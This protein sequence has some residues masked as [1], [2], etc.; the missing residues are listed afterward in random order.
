MFDADG[1][2]A[3]PHASAVRR[4]AD[5]CPATTSTSAAAARDRSFRD[6]GITFSP[7]GE[8]WVFPLD[9]IPRLIAEDEWELIEAGV[10]Q[11]VRALEA[12]LA[13]VY[14]A[15][16]CSATASCPTRWCPRAATSAGRRTASARQRASAS[17][18]PASTSSATP[19][20]IMR[21]LEDNLRVPSGISYVVENRRGDGAGLPRAVPGAAGAAGRRVRR[22]G[23]STRCAR[24][25]P[26]GVERPDRRAARPPGVTTRPTSS[27]PS[28]PA[29]W[30]SSWSRGATCSATTTSSTCAP[31]RRDA[32]RRRLPADRRRLPRPGALPSGLG[33]R[34]P[35]HPQRR[36]RRQR[37][38]RQRGRQRRGRRQADL[39]LRAGADRVLPRR[40]SRCCRTSRPTGSTSPTSR[41]YALERLDQLVVKPVDGS[42]GH[43]IVIGPHA[44]DAEL[45]AVA[46]A[47]A[48]LPAGGSPRSW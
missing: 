23:C 32:G 8:E 22:H 27:T 24:S 38:H 5:C 14:G 45:A 10:V 43:G 2:A 7:S 9:L 34:L 33:R 31:R 30:A 28:W 19:T 15:A 16:R 21:V 44:T 17:T 12:F 41:A 39:H 46:R 29:R 47:G 3:C 1:A 26:A 36:T 42:G 11:R 4:A 13:D 35:G 6:Q 20:G 37:H 25:A 40:A 18:S 48:R